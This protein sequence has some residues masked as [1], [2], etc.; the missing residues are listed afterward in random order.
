MKTPLLLASLSLS[1]LATGAARADSPPDLTGTWQ[2]ADEDFAAARVGTSNKYFDDLPKP[3]FGTPA[4]AFVY[5]IDAQEG[6]AF[7]GR[8]T[9][10]QGKSEALVGVI[11]FDNR[12]ILMSGDSGTVQGR[13][14]DDKLE[15]CWVDA[16]PTWN[17]VS[18]GL[19]K[20]AK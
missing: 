16:L 6:R 9:G 19:F 20:K 13:L 14:V 4:Q 15:L 5:T 3:T 7:H 12:E 8:A 17:A 11:R 1:V 2:L 18:C 10:P